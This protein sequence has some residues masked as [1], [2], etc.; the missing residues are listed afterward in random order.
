M[1]PK[2]VDMA[3][4]PAERKED[5]PMMASS[6]AAL[7]TYPYGLCISLCDDEL[8]KLKLPADCEVGD[9]LHMHCLAKVTSV[10]KNETTDGA[11]TR[12][13]L[14]ITAIAAE[15]EDGE[16]EDAERAMPDKIGGRYK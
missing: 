14:Q 5:M 16:N 8:A 3:I 12:I 15:D 1:M 10:S 6:P 9:M 7:P 13:E 2:F 4:T 11:R